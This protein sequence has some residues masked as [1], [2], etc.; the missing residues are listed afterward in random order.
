[1]TSSTW[2]TSSGQVKRKNLFRNNQWQAPAS[3]CLQFSLG[4]TP[5]GWE[6]P[7]TKQQR[8]GSCIHHTW[9]HSAGWWQSRLTVKQP[10]TYI[11]S[12]EKHRTSISVQLFHTMQ[13]FKNMLPAHDITA[14]SGL[15]HGAASHSLQ[16]CSPLPSSSLNRSLLRAGSFHRPPKGFQSFATLQATAKVSCFST[17]KQQKKIPVLNFKWMGKGGETICTTSKRDCSNPAGQD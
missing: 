13:S 2:I 14:Y 1:M 11:K 15:S 6:L 16:T 9:E 17:D 3:Y 5:A 12:T 4:F 8:W 7:S 10:Q